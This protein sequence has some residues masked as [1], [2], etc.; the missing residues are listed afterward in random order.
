MISRLPAAGLRR[1]LVLL[2]WLC[3]LLLRAQIVDDTTKA[4]YGPRTTLVVREVNV[5]RNLPEGTP[6]DTTINGIQQSR[7][8]F[9]DSTY[10][11]DLGNYATASRR[12]LWEV[13]TNIGARFGRTAF[14]KYFPE[15]TTI[16]YYDTR[17]PYSFFRF[18]QGG[19][20]ESVFEGMY[21]R[22]IKKAVNLGIAYTRFGGDK[23]LASAPKVGLTTHSGVLL[24][25]RYQTKDDRYQLLANYYIG[26]HSA[27]EQGG[28]RPGSQDRLDSL[29]GLFSYNQE[30][31]WLSQ[32]TNTDNRDRFHLAHTYRLVGRGLTAFHVLD[33]G[34]QYN[35]YEDKALPYDNDTL[36]YYPR[37]LLDSIRT[38]DRADYHQVENTVGVL[39]RTD[40]LE[41]RLYGRVRNTRLSTRNLVYFPAGEDLR[42]LLPD[43]RAN[44]LFVGGSVAFRWK[45]VFDV[46]GAGEYKFPDEYWLRGSLRYGPLRADLTSS[47]YAPSF[48]ETQLTSN[49]YRWQ[50][51]F[52][53]TLSNELKV[54]LNQR[55][56]RREARLQQQVRASVAVANVTDLVYYN[57]LAEPA[58]L[59]GSQQL[60][61]GTLRHQLHLGLLHTDNEVVLT[62]GGSGEGLRIPPVV[63]N[64]KVYAEGF[65]FKKALFSQIGLETYYQARWQPYDYAPS[66]QQFFVQDHFTSRSYPIVDAFVTADIKTV[67]VFL[68]M[69][70]LNQGI[71]RNGYFASPYYTGNPRS[72]QFGIKWNF[73]D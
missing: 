17:S 8:W 35:R 73:F 24:F 38:D 53:N 11:Q 71:Y 23:Q 54:S 50:N 59:S 58:Q 18:I 57:Q 20:G 45:Q 25:G 43:R 13:N 63:A 48:T 37:A 6:I 64:L 4:L 28:I 60:L 47:A 30:N 22:S 7:H 2:L 1:G 12:L 31:V 14:D 65:L 10:Q 3:P 44:Q 51:N 62:Q 72:F 56:G 34:R 67:S 49:H 36:R 68:K 42:H 52:S 21:S 46:E 41:Y 16:P 33:W 66:T 5:L 70:Y 15:P 19:T 39:G 40:F 61:I 9:Y 69:A 55:I 27:V 26:R 32:A 29:R